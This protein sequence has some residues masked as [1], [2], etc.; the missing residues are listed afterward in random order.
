MWLQAV[1]HTCMHVQVKQRNQH[2]LHSHICFFALLASRRI[3][4]QQ[5]SKWIIC[6]II[7]NTLSAQTYTS[8]YSRLSV[9]VVNRTIP[10]FC[11]A[12]DSSKVM[13]LSSSSS[14]L[15]HCCLSDMVCLP[16]HI[17][18]LACWCRPWLKP[19]GLSSSLHVPNFLLPGLKLH[20]PPH[21][22]HGFWCY[23][24]W[25]VVSPDHSVIHPHWL[26]VAGGN[27]CSAYVSGVVMDKLTCY[28]L[29]HLL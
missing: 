26:P 9:T 19:S 12:Q 3:K 11:E 18:M 2:N 15:C 1:T 13:P 14:G 29:C 17:A 8:V 5:S 20:P 10:W 6:F 4:I 28:F 22:P 16:L 21:P 24:L 7:R 25:N 27:L 23:L